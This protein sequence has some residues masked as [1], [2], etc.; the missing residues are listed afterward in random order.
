[1]SSLFDIPA[2]LA[3]L[4]SL[5]AATAGHEPPAPLKPAREHHAAIAA[6]P[7]VG[8]MRFGER[9]WLRALHESGVEAQGYASR[10]FVTSGGRY[11]VPATERQR[12]LEARTDAALAARVARAAAERNAMRLRAATKRAPAAGD[13]YI[14]HIFGP[15]V[16]I[17]LLR[18]VGEDAD[19]PLKARL[20]ALAA[21]VAEIDEVR[22][23]TLS[24]SQFYRQLAGALREPPR[25]VAIGLKP[26]VAD[27]PGA[28]ADADEAERPMLAWQARV[29]A[30]KVESG[31]A[32][33]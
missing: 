25:L 18:A 5:A 27:A 17:S 24:V 11:Y 13:L 26:S 4:L 22:G 20:P 19:A 30:A 29:D 10:V 31:S 14:A 8:P 23:K 33:Q 12:I 1:V 32:P 16:A 2:Q 3:M 21:A 28:T 15:E 7:L 6:E 9:A